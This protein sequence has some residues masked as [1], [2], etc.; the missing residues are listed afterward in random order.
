MKASQS[1]LL[2][3][4]A[5]LACASIAATQPWIKNKDGSVLLSPEGAQ[6]LLQNFSDI[7]SERDEYRRRYEGLQ[8]FVRRRDA[9]CV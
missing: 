5:L 1:I 8:E 2:G 3:A 6:S 7:V 9:R 4:A